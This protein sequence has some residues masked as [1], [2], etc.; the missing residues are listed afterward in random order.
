[1]EIIFPFPLDNFDFD[2]SQASKVFSFAKKAKKQ[3][4]NESFERL[5]QTYK[6]SK[7][8]SFRLS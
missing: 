1:M 8:T 7:I 6:I 2:V 4:R 3:T 5:A